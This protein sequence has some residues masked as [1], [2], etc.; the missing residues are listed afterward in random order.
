[1]CLECTPTEPT[2]EAVELTLL[3]C[4]KACAALPPTTR[5]PCV[6]FFVTVTIDYWRNYILSNGQRYR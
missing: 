2:K 5:E 1:M 4:V 6:T 3:P